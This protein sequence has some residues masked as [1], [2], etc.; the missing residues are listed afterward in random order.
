M[1]GQMEITALKNTFADKSRFTTAEL[2]EFFKKERTQISFKAIHWKIHTLKEN[3]VI[4]SLGRGIYQWKKGD[5]EQNK[6][7][8]AGSLSTP[9]RSLF[10]KIHAEFPLIQTCV[11]SVRWVHE[12]MTHVPSVNWTFVEVDKDVSESVFMFL[13]QTRHDVYLNPDR[14]EMEHYL[15]HDRKAIIVKDLISQA[16]L[17]H[18]NGVPCAVLEKMIVDLCVDKDVF[19]IYQGSELKN[20]L[21]EGFGKYRMNLSRLKRYATRR[22]AWDQISELLSEVMDIRK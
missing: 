17:T 19:D 21:K 15:A 14:A 4:L 1:N 7:E 16:P 10:S 9:Q 20:I 5:Q 22:N 12:F 2:A 13:R 18:S 11:W 8:F 3:G 6:I